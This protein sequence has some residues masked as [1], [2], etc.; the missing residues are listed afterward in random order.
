MKTPWHVWVIG[1]VSLLWNAGGAN[2]YVMLKFRN[3][4]YLQSMTPEQ[5]AYFEG[6]PVWV[7]FFWAI[8]V[9]AAVIGSVLLLLRS[10]HAVMAFVLS[11]VGM[12]V[13]GV[14][15]FALSD[16]SMTDI[17]GPFALAFSVIIVIVAIL[18]IHYA[19]TM[20]KRGVLR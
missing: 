8:G 11:L 2:N 1:V 3:P 14:Y 9:W 15:N 20:T 16:I 19:R 18:L 5:L 17:G 6:F 13:N 4:T 10:R 7:T 12:I